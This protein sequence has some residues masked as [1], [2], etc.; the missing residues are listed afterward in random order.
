MV[1]YSEKAK[2]IAI[3]TIR[4]SSSLIIILGLVVG[5][6]GVLQTEFIPDP[7][8]K[9]TLVDISM[10][11]SGFGVPLIILGLFCLFLGILGCCLSKCQGCISTTLFII[12]AGV[13]AFVL[14]IVGAIMAGFVGDKFFNRIKRQACKNSD[15]IFKEYTASIDMSLCTNDCPCPKGKKSF[16]EDYWTGLPEDVLREFNRVGEKTQLNDNELRDWNRNKDD[17]G[18]LPLV[19]KSNG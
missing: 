13:F 12:F 2:K 16:N 6:I 18:V 7:K 17:A 1:C 15:A 8:K 9:H 10:E 5:V 4:W 14:I 3:T 11:S 19:F